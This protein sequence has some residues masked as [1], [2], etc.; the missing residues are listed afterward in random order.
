MVRKGQSA[1]EYMMTYGWAILVIVIVAAVLYS[2]GIFS[3]SSS[4]GTGFTGFAPFTISSQACNS[5]GLYADFVVGGIP[6]GAPAGIQSASITTATGLSSTTGSVT[7]LPSSQVTSGS[8]ILVKFVGDDCAT[9][10]AHYSASVSLTYDYSSGLGPQ[11]PTTT[12]TI[13]GSAS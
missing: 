10:G 4:I 6:S 9:P 11:T 3:P 2:L 5:T 7:I 1:L 13:Y 8:T 12:G